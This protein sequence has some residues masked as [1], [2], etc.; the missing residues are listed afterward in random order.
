MIPE[1]FKITTPNNTRSLM[2]HETTQHDTHIKEV[3][4]SVHAGRTTTSEEQAASVL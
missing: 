3:V 2:I 4:V 1:P